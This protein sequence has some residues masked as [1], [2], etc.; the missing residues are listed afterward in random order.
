MADCN[1]SQTLLNLRVGPA[2]KE[3]GDIEK[4]REEEEEKEN[5]MGKGREEEEIWT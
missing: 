2:G 5:E 1:L 4:G 3:G